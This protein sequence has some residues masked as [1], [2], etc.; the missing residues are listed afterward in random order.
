MPPPPPK[1]GKEDIC[2]ISS[3]D[4]FSL[5]PHKNKSKQL[6]VVKFS[7]FKSNFCVQH[8]PKEKAKVPPQNKTATPI[9][10]LQ[11]NANQSTTFQQRNLMDLSR[12]EV[13]AKEL[14]IT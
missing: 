8:V 7:I 3:D 5:S 12:V 11:S 4:D 13:E 14:T 6:G 9:F 1:L 2:I 10:G